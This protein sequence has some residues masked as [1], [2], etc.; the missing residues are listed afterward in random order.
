MQMGDLNPYNIEVTCSIST[1]AAA[2]RV[3][4]PAAAAARAKRLAAFRAHARSLYT[5]TAPPFGRFDD[6]SPCTAALD[7]TTAYLAEPTV[8]AA[9]HVTEGATANGGWADCAS[10]SQL[11]YTRMPQDERVTVYPGLLKAI[12]VLIFNGDQVSG[13]WGWPQG[14]SRSAKDHVR[15]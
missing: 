15:C 14:Q 4:T 7:A 3:A 13:G 10:G 9:L 2:A 6:S 12:G 8:L 5:G 1:A 11:S